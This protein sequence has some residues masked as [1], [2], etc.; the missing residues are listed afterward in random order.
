MRNKPKVH[1]YVQQ[2]LLHDM[3]ACTQKCMLR[4]VLVTQVCIIHMRVHMYGLC[5]SRCHGDHPNPKPLMLVSMQKMLL[6][7][8]TRVYAC[9]IWRTEIVFYLKLI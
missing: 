4:N 9:Q 2:S 8:L 3:C 1:S 7:T 5:V 6:S